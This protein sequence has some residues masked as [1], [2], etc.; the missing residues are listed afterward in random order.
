MQELSF[1]GVRRERLLD[2]QVGR[3]RNQADAVYKGGPEGQEVSE[4][5]SP[6]STFSTWSPQYM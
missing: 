1:K 2:S 4:G 5:S 6:S 3:L